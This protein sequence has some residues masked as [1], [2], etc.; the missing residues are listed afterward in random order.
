MLARAHV[1]PRLF[2]TLSEVVSTA[3]A[4]AHSALSSF[5]EPLC[6]VASA[7]IGQTLCPG[8]LLDREICAPVSLI[9]EA[10]G[11]PRPRHAGWLAFDIIWMI[12]VKWSFQFLRINKL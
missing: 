9:H 6:F 12:F 10:P 5:P 7:A 8:R 2:C 3:A 1:A 11:V 4:H